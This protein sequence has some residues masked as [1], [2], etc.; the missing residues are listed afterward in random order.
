MLALALLGTTRVLAL[1]SNLMVSQ[2]LHRSW[3]GNHEVPGGVEY[4]AQAPSGIFLLFGRFGAAWFDGTRWQ[5]LE[6]GNGAASIASTEISAAR[7]TSKSDIWIGLRAGGVSRVND[8]QLTNYTVPDGFPPGTVTAIAEDA[9]GD[10]WVAARS[11]L[12]R[13]SGSRW[14]PI[15]ADWNVPRQPLA[16]VFADR[17]GNIWVA[18]TSALLRLAKGARRFEQIAPLDVPLDGAATFAQSQDG[19]VWVSQAAR[20]VTHI[21][22]N[23]DGTARVHRL[24]ADLSVDTLLVDR[25]GNLWLGGAGLHRMTPTQ[26]RL[27]VSANQGSPSLDAFS[28]DDGLSSNRVRSLFEDREGNLWVSTAAGIDRFARSEVVRAP[29]PHGLSGDAAIIATRDNTVWI[30]DKGTPAILKIQDGKLVQ[31]I[32]S[33]PF[34]VSYEDP[35]GTLWFGGPAGV[36][37]LVGN[38]LELTPLPET[39]AGTDVRA[40]A[41]DRDGR[42]W[43]ALSPDGLFRL[44]DG[45]WQPN[46]NLTGLPAQSPTT[47]TTDEHGDVWL[48]YN[49]S[50]LARISGDTVTLFGEADH[51]QV[52]VVNVL[53]ASGP[54][55]W[56]GGDRGL[57]LF[58]GKRFRQLQ[59]KNCHRL[60]A[61]SGIVETQDG[62]LWV[63]RPVGVSQFAQGLRDA[64]TDLPGGVNMLNCSRTLNAQHGIPG[65]LQFSLSRPVITQ[66]TDGKIWLAAAGGAGW[67]DPH[68]VVT[69][70]RPPPMT[71]RRVEANDR[72]LPAKNGMKLPPGT[73]AITIQYEGW[74]LTIPERTRYRYRLRGIDTNW[75]SV[76]ERHEAIYTNLGPG[77]YTFEVAGANDDLEWTPVPA[78]LE[79]VI[80]PKLTQTPW[81]YALCAVL[82]MGTLAIL[83]RLQ[84]SRA[85]TRLHDRLEE[86]MMERERIA[87]E[88]HDTLLQG[89]QGLILRFQAVSARIPADAPAHDMMER[90]LDQ[91]DAVLIE[92]RDR[93]SGLRESSD[94]SANLAQALTDASRSL[95]LNGTVETR[96]QIQGT[97][98]ALD[99]GVGAEAFLIAREALYNALRHSGA[100][101]IEIELHY[102]RGWLG[103]TVRDNGRGIGD[104]IL[105]AGGRSGHWGLR[106]MRERARKLRGMLEIRSALHAGTEV[107]LRVPA[108]LAYRIRVTSS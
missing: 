21:E 99:P 15:G 51:F 108:V 103:V 36:A 87:R 2:F 79:F 94:G 57:A 29:V 92:S 3:I 74:S 50:Q 12:A 61:T 23:R 53:Y 46:G 52:G 43:V 40:L 49:Q 56:I 38:R 67:I 62:E 102:D 1:D 107:E 48:G 80:L 45:R 69:N 8:G 17:H 18:T 60:S 39:A 47:A 31:T 65:S 85:S 70:A 98:K 78:M 82:I 44:D 89:V 106:G 55:L 24:F 30:A 97:V 4:F 54:R 19:A 13:I 5:P 68:H 105:R 11:G 10:I 93:V 20:G 6:I 34:T 35:R 84:L 100:S 22:M 88:L 42:L 7:I 25:D 72:F 9:T 101:R 32:A 14:R 77:K 41:S 91:A 66:S 59:S 58:D 28:A 73:T 64:L 83:F 104:E 96:V 81:F 63:Y 16:G 86:R 33:P 76:A 75:Q 37:R 26:S 95:S 27:D 90:A 71:F